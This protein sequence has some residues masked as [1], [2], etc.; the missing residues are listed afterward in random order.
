MNKADCFFFCLHSLYSIVSLVS[1][2]IWQFLCFGFIFPLSL[3]PFSLVS[4][5]IWFIMANEVGALL[6]C[7]F[8]E[9]IRATATRRFHCYTELHDA[10]LVVSFV[11]LAFD[12]FAMTFFSFSSLLWLFSFYSVLLVLSGVLF[13]RWSMPLLRSHYLWHSFMADSARFPTMFLRWCDSFEFL[14]FPGI[15]T[16]IKRLDGLNYS[17]IFYIFDESMSRDF[18]GDCDMAERLSVAY[19][20]RI[21]LW[22]CP[23]M[24][25]SRFWLHNNFRCQRTANMSTHRKPNW[26]FFVTAQKCDIRFIRFIRFHLIP[27]V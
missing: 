12:L 25:V 4:P 16:L 10:H 24:K 27:P 26:I 15:S 3:A 9:K 8:H 22:P 5:F 14:F 21:I 18:D 1:T 6:C 23:Q 20:K 13:L 2:C 19:H 7:H 11:E 17:T